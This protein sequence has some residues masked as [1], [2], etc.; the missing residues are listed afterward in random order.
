M[1]TI[2]PSNGNYNFVAECIHVTNAANE[3]RYYFA[4]PKETQHSVFTRWREIDTRFNADTRLRAGTTV[5]EDTSDMNL[6]ALVSGR[7]IPY[8]DETPLSVVKVMSVIRSDHSHVVPTKSIISVVDFA[9]QYE[10]DMQKKRINTIIQRMREKKNA[11][12]KEDLISYLYDNDPEVEE[13]M[14]EFKN[15][16]NKDF[17]F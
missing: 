15:L 9:D 4:I 12:V 11:F 3:K 17:K 7:Q 6:F 2:K 1:E 16:T 5:L 8:S 14:D 10:R 13:L